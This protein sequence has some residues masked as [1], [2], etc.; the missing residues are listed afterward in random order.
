MT[1]EIAVS[2]AT[3]AQGVAQMLTVFAFASGPLLV[4]LLRRATSSYSAFFF[5]MAALTLVMAVIAW[6]TPLPRLPE[7]SDEPV[8]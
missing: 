5:L 6:F 3:T 4:S 7:S 8:Q 2:P 1:S